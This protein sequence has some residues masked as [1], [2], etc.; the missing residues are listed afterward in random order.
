MTHTLDR[1]T[2]EYIDTED[3]IRL[4]GQYADGAAVVIWL[5]RRLIQRLVPVLLEWLQQQHRQDVAVPHAEILQGWAQQAA[6][7]GLTIQPPV[8]A[9]AARSAWLVDS[10]DFTPAPEGVVLT[11]KSANDQRAMLTLPA[12]ALRQWLNIVYD[13][14]VRAE[15]PRAVWPDWI[16]EAAVPVQTPSVVMH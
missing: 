4:S 12:A 8:Q 1:I 14:Y 5:T 11:F 16:S 6:R 3:R 10:I 7:A 15:W 2:T 13:A 9:T